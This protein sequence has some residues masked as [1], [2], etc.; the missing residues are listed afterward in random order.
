HSLVTHADAVGDGGGA[1]RLRNTP[2]G[3]DAL[4]ALFREPVEVGITRGDVAEERCDPDHRLLEIFVGEAD[5]PEH[6]PVRGP[7]GSARCGQTG[8][9]ESVSH[10]GN[11]QSHL[12]GAN[13]VIDTI[14]PCCYRDT[15]RAGHEVWGSFPGGANT[16]D[17]WEK[18]GRPVCTVSA[19][20]L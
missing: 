17:W 5:G 4:A 14:R 13:G 15:T 7:P 12:R 11:P 18:Y 20:E 10:G 16:G 9:S 6:G 3:A 19:C 1:E 2:R 8:A